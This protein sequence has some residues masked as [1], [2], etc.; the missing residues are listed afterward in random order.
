MAARLT[1]AEA[2]QLV[3]TAKVRPERVWQDY[4]VNRQTSNQCNIPLATWELFLLLTDQHPTK[5]LVD[6]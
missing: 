2:A 4:E 5:K 1:Q 3:S 6:R